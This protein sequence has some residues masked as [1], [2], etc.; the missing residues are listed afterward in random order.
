MSTKPNGVHF[1]ER[2]EYDRLPR[3]NWSKLKWLDTSPAHYHSALLEPFSD[4]DAM[5]QGRA[6]HLAVFE[7]EQFKAKCVVF[8]GKVRRG[9]D[10]NKFVDRHPDDEILTV[11]QYE[12]ALAVGRAVGSSAQAKPYVSGGNGEV[13]VLWDYIAPVTAAGP[14]FKVECK[15][16][17]DFITEW[18]AIVDLKTVTRVGGAKPEAFGWT[19]KN[20]KY[21]VQAAFYRRAYQR[22]T[23]K[24]LPYYF[25]AV[26]TQA[27]FAVQVYRVTDQQLEEGEKVFKQLFEIYNGCRERSRWPQYS[28]EVLELQL[29]L[30][31][32][33]GDDGLVE[34]LGLTPAI[35]F[36]TT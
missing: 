15:S 23:G 20:L 32:S 17:L 8:E 7:P 21:D 30:P 6:C 5:K 2:G 33:D 25:V 26:E 14:G 28:D 3:V 12:T 10:W 29:P 31:W 22:A 24:L 27:P 1:I 9:D 13:T 35:G 11:H 4:T 19:C 16:R 36:G 34:E 18:G